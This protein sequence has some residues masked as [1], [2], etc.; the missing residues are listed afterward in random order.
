[1]IG[2]MLVWG[3]FSAMGWMGANWAMDRLAPDKEIK[4]EQVCSAWIEEQKNGI[5]YRSRVCEPT[6]TS[7]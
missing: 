3:F 2:E 1:M 4:H 7:P 5:T 6:K